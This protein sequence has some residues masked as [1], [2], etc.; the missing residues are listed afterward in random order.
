MPKFLTRPTEVDAFQ[1]DPYK[2]PWPDGVTR[3]YENAGKFFMDEPCSEDSY[4]LR[5]GD[6]IVTEADGRRFAVSSLDFPKSY[7]PLPRSPAGRLAGTRTYLCGA[8]DRVPDGGV[9]W[10]EEITPVL[11]E[12]G[13]IVFDPA[14]KPIASVQDETD[15]SERERWTREGDWEK[16]RRFVK[17]IRGQDLRM[18]NTCDFVI[19]R[20]DPD[21]HMCGSYEEMAIANHEKKPILVWTVGGK[22][23]TPWWLFGMLPHEHIFGSR[24]DLLAYLDHV[25]TAPRVRGFRRWFFFKQDVLYNRA[26]LGKLGAC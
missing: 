12:K 9:P 24:E 16:I 2:K 5:P 4:I 21:V 3:D 14:H 26:V 15:K 10:R 6:W 20:V 7:A 23:R 19:A 1:F 17:E 18:V 8:M 13:V 11:Q 22:H 25:D